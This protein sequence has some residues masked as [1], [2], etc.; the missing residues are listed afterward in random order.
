MKNYDAVT[1]L[2]PDELRLLPLLIRARLAATVCIAAW[3][4]SARAADDPYLQM[5]EDGSR[6]AADFLM[7]LVELGDDGF[8]RLL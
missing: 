6:R 7:Q 2:Q 4:A 8:Q 1:P 3:R 5:G